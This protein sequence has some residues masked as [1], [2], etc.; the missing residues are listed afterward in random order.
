MA[1]DVNPTAQVSATSVPSFEDAATKE[2]DTAVSTLSSNQLKQNVVT[3]WG[4]LF[5]VISCVAPMAA[6]VFNTVSWPAIAVP[7]CRSIS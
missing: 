6:A 5:V 1:E 7:R 4:L 3:L 2:G